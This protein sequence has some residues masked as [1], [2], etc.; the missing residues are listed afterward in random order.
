MDME[1][2][3]ALR[4]LPQ[5]SM[6]LNNIFGFVVSDEKQDGN[7]K[8]ESSNK[9]YP[10]SIEYHRSKKNVTIIQV[11]VNWYTQKLLVKELDEFFK[12]MLE[13]I[14]LNNPSENALGSWV[15]SYQSLE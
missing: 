2:I 1:L 8:L 3:D 4:I 12:G 10:M 13:Y 9:K 5:I 6:E 15:Y 7:F 14:N 11:R